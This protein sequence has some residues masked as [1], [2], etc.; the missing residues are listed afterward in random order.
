[1]AVYTFTF[2]CA[3]SVF[4][5]LQVPGT[6]AFFF[7]WF[8]GSSSSEEEQPSQR[9]SISKADQNEIVNKHNDV[10]R[11]VQPTA[12]NMM[13]MSWSSEAAANAQKWANKCTMKHSPDSSRTISSSECGENLYM[14]SG[15]KT[16]S[17]A[18][19]KWT[20]EV[21]DWRYGVGSIN[22]KVVGHYTQMVWHNS[23][24]VG[25]GIAYCP[26]STY[27]YYYVCQ[28]CPPGNYQY[29]RPYKSGRSCG[30]CPNGCD[31]KLCGSI[32]SGGTSQR[33]RYKDKASNCRSLKQQ[34]SCKHGLV[35]SW[36]P[37]SCKC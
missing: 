4:A 27:K 14:S 23:N 3:L 26:N 12:S 10:R 19:Q 17:Q 36:C 33:C 18:I 13:K 11:S 24:K 5:A 16:W 25:C 8:G 6:D 20:N 37:A 15:K 34:L 9:L 1:M 22:G 21:K 30:D 2:L 28:Y 29:A 35:A 32:A 7:D 31:N